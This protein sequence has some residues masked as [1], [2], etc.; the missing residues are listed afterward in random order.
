MHILK[1]FLVLVLSRFDLTAVSETGQELGDF[2]LARD[3]GHMA[4]WRMETGQPIFLQLR[5]R[6]ETC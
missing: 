4:L 3:F 6:T 1:M 5:K 2:F